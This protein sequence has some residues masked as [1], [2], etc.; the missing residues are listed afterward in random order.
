MG[1]ICRG[2]DGMAYRVKTSEAFGSAVVHGLDRAV[3]ETRLLE[4]ESRICLTGG[5]VCV[6][7]H[8]VTADE[9]EG[10]EAHR[11]SDSDL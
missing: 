1:I 6:V 8:F 5:A 10:K 7:S 3:I 4:A 9:V 11:W 2:T